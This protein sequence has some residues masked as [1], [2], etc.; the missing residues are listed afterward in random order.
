[1]NAAFEVIPPHVPE[2]GNESFVEISVTGGGLTLI[3]PVET[4]PATW[5]VVQFRL[6]PDAYVIIGRQEGGRIPYMDPRFR[7]T[8]IGPSGQSILTSYGHGIDLCVSRGHF[9]LRGAAQGIQF[10]NGVP[11]PGGSIRA[12]LNGTLLVE[13]VRRW[14]AQG[15]EYL[16]ERGQF[17]KI[18]LPN[19]TLVTIAAG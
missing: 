12:P 5:P 19:S 17:I 10:V 11:A 13:P 15:E 14:F 7:S 9:M 8:Q 6:S 18:C 4:D 2:F 1:M 3:G 16:V